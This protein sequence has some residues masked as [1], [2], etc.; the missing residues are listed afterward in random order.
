MSTPCRPLS[1]ALVTLVLASCGDRAP[2]PA[3]AGAAQRYTV[4]GELVRIEG[5]GDARQLWIRHEAIPDFAD[6]N[7][8][9]VGMSAMVMPFGVDPG[10][11][12]DGV[13]PGTKVRFRLAVD[14]SR[15]RLAIE[16][17]EPLPADAPLDFGGAR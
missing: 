1:L 10:V 9:K 14:W 2:P 6:R 13:T 15:N 17:L 7:G 16:S 12:L 3:P 5:S 8:A 11:S 4:R